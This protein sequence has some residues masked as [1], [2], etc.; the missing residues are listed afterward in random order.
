MEQFG[1]DWP[2]IA[3]K[4]ESYADLKLKGEDDGVVDW[5]FLFWILED[6]V[7][8]NVM[9]EKLNTIL[10]EMHIIHVGGLSW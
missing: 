10:P 7:R 1:D 3:K 2:I 9:L 4:A 8:I 6:K 5:L